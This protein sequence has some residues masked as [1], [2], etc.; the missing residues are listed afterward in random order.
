MVTAAVARMLLVTDRNTLQWLYVDSPLTEEAS[1]VLYKLPN[2]SSLSVVI[3]RKA[4]LPSASLP[5]LTELTITCDDEDDWPRL[6]HG[7]TLEKL[8]SVTFYPQSEQIGDFLGTFEVA[9][10]SS[11]AQNALSGFYLFTQYSWN[12]NYSSLL[13]FTQ[14]MEIHVESP[15]D[16]GCSSTVDDDIVIDLSRAMPKLK[17]LKL[18]GDP[19]SQFTTGITV[20]GLLALAYHCPNL[21]VLRIHFHVASLS[22]PPASPGTIPNAKSTVSWTDCALT[23]LEVGETSVSEES[24][25]MVSLT[26]LR[27]F[28]RIETIDGADEGWAK[29]RG[30]INRSK[31]IIDCSSK[32]HP[33]TTP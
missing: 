25:L 3:D 19:C 20:K 12:P 8:E 2:L 22:E 10:L 23:D 9:A 5:N 14:M 16:D 33:L 30:A 4:L 31:G 29:V 17:V 13:P 24:V 28:P 11:S 32:Q 18:G 6:F 15:C 21:S 26:L 27:I 1:E 7:A